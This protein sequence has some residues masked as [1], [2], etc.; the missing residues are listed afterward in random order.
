MAPR[1]HDSRGPADRSDRANSQA[2]AGLIK[3]SLLLALKS[4]VA[5]HVPFFFCVLF[6]LLHL[7]CTLRNSID[8]HTNTPVRPADYDICSFWR[9]LLSPMSHAPVA[10]P[11]T[12]PTTATTGWSL[13]MYAELTA[14]SDRWIAN[15]CCQFLVAAFRKVSSAARPESEPGQRPQ[16]KQAVA[17]I[18]VALCITDRV[19]GKS[20]AMGN[21]WGMRPKKLPTSGHCTGEFWVRDQE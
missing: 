9:L 6:I 16:H 14:P 10:S 4:F 11:T 3:T 17:T 13:R 8:C 12:T 19:G 20:K 21:Q 5:L 1:L 7:C 15:C 2:R 18:R